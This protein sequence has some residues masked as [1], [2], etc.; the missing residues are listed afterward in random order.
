[1]SSYTTCADVAQR[2]KPEG[3]VW[4]GEDEHHRH[5]RLPAGT[6]STSVQLGALTKVQTSRRLPPA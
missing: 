1:M 6:L 2:R 3:H 4:M 5:A